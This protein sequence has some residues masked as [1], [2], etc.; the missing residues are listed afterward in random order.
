MPGVSPAMAR[1]LNDME[2]SSLGGSQ[3]DHHSRRAVP[4][5]VR[6]S[7]ALQNS[8]G[9]AEL[10]P[11]IWWQALYS[12]DQRFDGRFFIGAGTTKIYCRPVCP[13]PFA[14][15][16][17]L[18]WFAS[19]AAAEAAGYR[20]CG[21][22]RPEASPGTPAWLG[23]SAIVSRA[24]RLISEGA[25]D[26]GSVEDL[27][28]R[29]GVGARQLRRL[30]VEHLGSSPVKIAITHRIHFA[31]N[32]IEET[33][34]PITKIALS[35]GFT[36]IR[37]FNHEVRLICGQS[38]TELRRARGEFPTSSQSGLV[39]RLAC[40]PPFDWPA[41]VE[42]LRPR[43]TPG[44]EVVQ[45]DA[46]QRT[47]SVGDSTGIIEV[48][49]GKTEPTLA[50]RIELPGCQFLMKV[51]DRVR[52]IFDLGA[53]PL[54]IVEDLSRYARLK[55]LLDR[56][57]GLRV[58]GAWDGFEL[59]V[60]AILGQQLT[61]T[62]STALAGRLVQA[63]GTP[64]QTSMQGLTH[65]FPTPKDLVDADL[66]RAG[67]RGAR[68]ATLHALAR[69]VCT[70]KFTFAASMTLEEAISR[71]SS[72][73]GIGEST[74]HYIAMRAL[75]EPDAFPFADPGLRKA[76]GRDESPVSPAEVLRITEDWRP[77]RAYAAM[78]LCAAV[79]ARDVGHKKKV[80]GHV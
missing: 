25:L 67:I 23:T 63:F 70:G 68:A 26:E 42:F 13:V 30:F 34:L 48:R 4:S 16:N 75:G 24:L 35:A 74:A 28:G 15:P 12:R 9:N 49:P 77:W 76:L 11:S 78:H 51:V 62:D 45:D 6:A 37:Q 31:R 55:P 65:L 2:F 61:V 47:I 14:R 71:L 32:L 57:P 53:D 79:T 58:P 21:R 20:P 3:P 66:S 80:N 60:H 46:Y 22:C 38:P 36:S 33:D 59:A 54:R 73:P 10:Q 41:L 5:S 19:A 39:I 56:H 40:R 69:A 27:A 72:I 1:F 29:V 43:A 8:E 50:V 64:L 17:S 18:V 7:L 52:R 44:V